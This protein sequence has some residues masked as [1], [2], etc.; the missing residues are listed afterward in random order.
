MGLFLLP[1]NDGH[2]YPLCDGLSLTFCMESVD[3]WPRRTLL[4]ISSHPAK[5]WLLFCPGNVK[6]KREK[7]RKAHCTH[8]FLFPY[9]TEPLSRP[10]LSEPI[11][12]LSLSVDCAG[13]MDTLYWVTF[14]N[15][16]LSTN[17]SAYVTKDTAAIGILAR[18]EPLPPFY[19]AWQWRKSRGEERERKK[20]GDKV[21]S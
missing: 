11:S 4:S 1:N 2:I 10:L 18:K 14:H 16:L 5:H 20:H 13:L 21:F 15:D 17:T 12:A 19:L 3:P 8:Y 7:T 6:Q 9:G